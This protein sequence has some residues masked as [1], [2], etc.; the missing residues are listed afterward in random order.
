MTGPGERIGKVAE[1]PCKY[2]H[3]H[4]ERERVSKRL[5]KKREIERKILGPR[6]YNCR[7]THRS[8]CGLLVLAGLSESLFSVFEH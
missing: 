3:R 7:S 4:G 5:G 1:R 6:H 2:T 8:L